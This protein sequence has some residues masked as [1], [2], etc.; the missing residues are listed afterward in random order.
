MSTTAWIIVVIVVVLAVAALVAWMAAQQRKRKHVEHAESLRHEAQQHA[1]EIPESQVRAKEAEAEAERARLEAERAREKAEE[2]KVAAT[3]QQAVHEDRL[4]TADQVDPR[5]DTASE[6]YSPD[7]VL[8]AD[9]A[10]RTDSGD[11]THR[12]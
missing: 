5:V 10:R 4:R 1:S 11:G 3:Q 9:D 8:D 6:G 7:T 12:A 2:A